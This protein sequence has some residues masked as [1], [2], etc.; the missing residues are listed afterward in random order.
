MGRAATEGLCRG[1][2]TSALP[3]ELAAARLADRTP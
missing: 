3:R 1:N 2:L